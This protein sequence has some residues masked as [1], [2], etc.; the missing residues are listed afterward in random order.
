MR[1]NGILLTLFFLGTACC[2]TKA[3]QFRRGEHT[4]VPAWQVMPEFYVSVP[5]PISGEGKPIPGRF[6]AGN[7]LTY[8]E[9]VYDPQ[10]R[11]HQVLYQTDF[12]GRLLYIGISQGL[13]VAFHKPGKPMIFFTKCMRDLRE[14]PAS[15]KLADQAMQCVIDRLN[16]SSQP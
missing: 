9:I 11:P 1:W 4:R 10:Q 3:Q 16:F 7:A 2:G 8:L 14:S 15:W 12:M 5:L 13:S 6:D